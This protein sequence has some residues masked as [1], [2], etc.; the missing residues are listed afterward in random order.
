MSSYSDSPNAPPQCPT[1]GSART[2]RV[3]R[4]GLMQTLVLHRF[5]IFP[6]QCSGCKKG[7]TFKHRGTARRRRR[8]S[9][10]G[11]VKLPPSLNGTPSQQFDF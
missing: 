3:A 11:V 6:W 9:S 2:I 10:N 4:K 8:T 1:C 7:F 5:G